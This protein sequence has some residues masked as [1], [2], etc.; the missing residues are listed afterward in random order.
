[1][2][3]YK[4]GDKVRMTTL[5][6]GERVTDRKGKPIHQNPHKNVYEGTVK[7][8]GPEC[9]FKGAAE[10]VRCNGGNKA[11]KLNAGFSFYPKD[12]GPEQVVE[13]LK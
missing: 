4:I 1:M 11:L 7:F 5:T 10:V 12:N 6:W 9:A 3:N 13:I 8:A 2:T